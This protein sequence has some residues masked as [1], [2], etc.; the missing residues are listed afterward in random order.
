MLLSTRI[1]SSKS[2]GII[3][4]IWSIELEKYMT[5][6]VQNNGHKLLAI[7]AMR[8][9]IHIFIAYKLNQLIPNLVAQIKL[10]SNHW[11]RSRKLSKYKFDW[12][13]G[14]SVFSYSHS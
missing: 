5:G 11:I 13:N 8:D 6:I 4:P 2:K 1:Q 7:K 3:N 14:F 9:H 12:E 10:S